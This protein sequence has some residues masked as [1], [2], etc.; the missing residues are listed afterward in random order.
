MIPDV[1]VMSAKV[2]KNISPED[3][4]IILEAAY[5]STDSHKIAWDAAI[6]EAIEEA[7]SQMNVE[8]VDD[9]D[10][11]AFRQATSG[12]ID[13]YCQQYPGVKAL[14]DIIDSVE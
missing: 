8:F 2:W 3:Q 11:E 12:M 4:Q 7:K 1:M 13:E 10:K 9:V 6:E 5:A 14:L